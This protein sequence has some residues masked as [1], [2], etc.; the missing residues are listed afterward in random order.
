MQLAFTRCPKT[1]T[2]S[3]QPLIVH[4]LALKNPIALISSIDPHPLN[5][6]ETPLSIFA[7]F[8]FIM[9]HQ[10]FKYHEPAR[11]QAKTTHATNLTVQKKTASLDHIPAQ[12]R[13]YHTMF[14]EQAS[15]CLPQHQPWDHAIDLKPDTVMKKCSI[16]HRVGH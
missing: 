9:Q 1:C 16:C 12:F 5:A 14:S 6:P 8:A 7:I 4:P 10:L 11:I 15:E 2:L 13:K 3:E